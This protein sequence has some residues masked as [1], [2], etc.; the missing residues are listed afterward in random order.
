MQESS[1]SSACHILLRE[2]QS[3]TQHFSWEESITNMVHHMNVDTTSYPQKARNEPT[4][5]APSLPLLCPTTKTH[6]MKRLRMD[7]SN[8]APVPMQL[9]LTSATQCS[10]APK[11]P[12]VSF[13]ECDHSKKMPAWPRSQRGC[14]DFSIPLLHWHLRSSHAETRTTTNTVT[15]VGLLP[16]NSHLLNSPPTWILKLPLP[17][18]PRVLVLPATRQ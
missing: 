9:P 10:G 8:L 14:F 15:Y 7:P 11:V 18:L 12:L 16:L 6:Q 4:S 17:P 1:P 13:G 5:F 2:V 3:T